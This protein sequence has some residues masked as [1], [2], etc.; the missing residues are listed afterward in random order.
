MVVPVNP[1]CYGSGLPVAPTFLVFHAMPVA[2]DQ[3][4]NTELIVMLCL[5]MKNV[6]F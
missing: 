1:D 3:K 6:A 5:L 2:M 4:E